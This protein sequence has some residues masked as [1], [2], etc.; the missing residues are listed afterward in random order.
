M[1]ATIY[2]GA[3]VR[4]AFTVKDFTGA[5]TD[6]TAI[7]ATIKAP[8]G[9]TSTKTLGGGGVLSTG[10]GAYFFIINAAQATTDATP[11]AWHVSV[12]VDDGNGGSFV[13]T[14]QKTFTVVKDN[15][16]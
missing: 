9:T 10:T 12:S 3:D 14:M 16:T 4:V 7:T 5:P 11:Y 13:G 15:T 2:Q 1:G 6:A 8:D